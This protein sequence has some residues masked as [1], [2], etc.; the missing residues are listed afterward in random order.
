VGKKT[1]YLIPSR[2]AA[3]IGI[4]RQAVSKATKTGILPYVKI[5]GKK[6]INTVDPI[7]QDYARNTKAVREDRDKK[8]KIKKSVKVKDAKTIEKLKSV[9]DPSDHKIIDE[10]VKRFP[11]IETGLMEAA[12]KIKVKDTKKAK[13]KTPVIVA[14]KDIPNYLKKMADS[15]DFT[16]VQFMGLSK[17]E[18]DKIKIYEGLK[19]IRVKTQRDKQELI[20]RKMVRVIFG[21]LY[22]I[23]T[24]QFLTL[25][26]KVVPDIASIMG[27]VDASKML[28]AEKRIDE[29]LYKILKHIKIEI[30]KFLKK[31][32]AERE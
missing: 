30:D 22:E 4:T 15:G 23:D 29:E 5:K 31:I 14:E 19:Q 20:S 9:V 6:L 2:F 13:N 12:N 3:S 24:N 17:S 28:E 27:C 21:K 1:K 8:P 16:L 10:M 18:A 26:N 32:G 7:V 11:G 25:K